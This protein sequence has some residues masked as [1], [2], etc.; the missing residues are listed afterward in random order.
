MN[1]IDELNSTIII[2]PNP[3]TSIVNIF[4][5]AESEMALIITN[6][7]GKTIQKFIIPA[8]T[9]TSV[10]ISDLKSG[11]YYTVPSGNKTRIA[12]PLIKK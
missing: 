3:A 9:T 6:E 12:N 7:I 11:I 2:F 8:D 10:D 4:S 1:E 5:K